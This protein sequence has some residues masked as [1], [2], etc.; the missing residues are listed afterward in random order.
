MICKGG[1]VPYCVVLL[2]A[3]FQKLAFNF[4]ETTQQALVSN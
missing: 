4:E 2:N 1:N 3:D